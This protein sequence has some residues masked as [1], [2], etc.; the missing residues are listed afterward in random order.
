MIF[1]IFLGVGYFTG[2]DFKHFLSLIVFFTGFIFIF[3]VPAIA[4]KQWQYSRLRQKT[5]IEVDE[6]KLT[7]HLGKETKY[8]DWSQI[9]TVRKRIDGKEDDFIEFVAGEQ[10]IVLSPF[11]FNLAEVWSRIEP[12][13]SEE[14]LLGRNYKELPFYQ[15]ILKE[16]EQLLKEI[17]TPL[18]TGYCWSLKVGFVVF[19]IVVIG[20]GFWGLTT[21]SLLAVK[22]VGS[23]IV[24]WGLWLATFSI[25]AQL[26][27][28]SD[29]LE[30]KKLWWHKQMRWSE[31]QMIEFD[32]NFGR[33]IFK[34]KDKKISF[35]SPQN[36]SGEDKKK[37]IEM[38][39]VQVEHLGINYSHSYPKNAL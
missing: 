21:S 19:G 7:L 2:L 20:L 17:F 32:H 8:F 30:T 9:L 11:W 23:F 31:I 3:V 14:A 36:W 35:T 10:I 24:L 12:Y 18:S 37:M 4:I 38:L 5:K 6:E 25:T 1:F 16:Q 26:T 28:T 27:M 29:K 33:V 22:L 13:L 15:S 34:A 39:N